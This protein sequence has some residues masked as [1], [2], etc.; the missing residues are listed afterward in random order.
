LEFQNTQNRRL[1]C[2]GGSFNPVHVGHLICARFAAERAGFGGV[3]LVVAQVNPHK[4]GPADAADLAPADDRLSMCQ[5]VAAGDPFF[6]VDARELA[7]PGPSYTLETARS[8]LADGSEPGPRVA[9]L[10]GTDHLPR[11][12]GWHGFADGG[13]SDVVE[14]VVMRR[15]GHPVDLGPLD[16]RVRAIAERSVEVPQIEV[17]STLVRR[18]VRAGRSVAHLTPPDVVGHIERGG[19]Y[20]GPAAEPP[21]SRQ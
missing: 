3:R 6:T 16:P 13:L 15:A 7:R 17:S 4:L 21:G 14:F 12:H 1:L 19:L 11:L 10:I 5:A 20:R 9:W 8:L 2:L 18:R